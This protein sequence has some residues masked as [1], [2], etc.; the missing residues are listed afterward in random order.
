MCFA[1][2][3]ERG[4][5]SRNSVEMTPFRENVLGTVFGKAACSEGSLLAAVACRSRAGFV[6]EKPGQFE[7]PSLCRSAFLGEEQRLVMTNCCVSD[8]R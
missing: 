4:C 2:P 6:F 7:I 3:K 5:H 1:S 8:S